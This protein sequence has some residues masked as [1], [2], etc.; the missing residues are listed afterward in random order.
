MKSTYPLA[1]FSLTKL[2]VLLMTPP[3]LWLA[4]VVESKISFY[5]H[6]QTVSIFQ[7]E[8]EVLHFLL[9]PLVFTLPKV[10][11]TSIVIAR[12]AYWYIFFT[13][14]AFY[15]FGIAVMFITGHL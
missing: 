4:V 5:P 11:T 15:T 12:R 13:V 7:Y 6:I 10:P 9:A 2:Q 14:I 8:L 1:N 3:L